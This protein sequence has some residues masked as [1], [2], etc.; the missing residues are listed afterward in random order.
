MTMTHLQ[1]G[2]CSHQTSPCEGA[3]FELHVGGWG[4]LMGSLQGCSVHTEA[5]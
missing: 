4:V 3:D 5:K 1:D 2:L